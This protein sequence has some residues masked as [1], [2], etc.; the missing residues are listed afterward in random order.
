MCGEAV[1]DAFNNRSSEARKSHHQ[2]TSLRKVRQLYSRKGYCI[3]K[4]HKEEAWIVGGIGSGASGDERVEDANDKV[5]G[6]C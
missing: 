1:A 6:V 5:E 4:R 2:V 3:K